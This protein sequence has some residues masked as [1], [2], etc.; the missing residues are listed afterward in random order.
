MTIKKVLM[1]AWIFP[2]LGGSGVQRTLKFSKYLPGLGWKPYI[3][4]SDDPQVFGDGLD[5]SLLTEIPEEAVIWRKPFISPLGF[6]RK[7]QK[8]LRIASKNEF[9]QPRWEENTTSTHSN[10]TNKTEIVKN[11]SQTADPGL[12]QKHFLKRIFAV[13]SIPLAPFEFPPVDAAVYWSLSILPG[14]LKIIRSEKINLIYSTSFPYSDH[15][16]GYLLKRLTGLPWVADFRDPWT[17][18]ASAR[19]QGWRFH[20]DQWVEKKVL[21]SADRILCVTPKYTQGLRRLAPS[22]PP[23]TFLTIENGFDPMDFPAKPAKSQKSSR[24][25]VL[26]HVGYLY[27]GTAIS[28]LNALHLLGESAREL[29]V[30]FIGGLASRE[31]TWLESHSVSAPI[32]ILP[33]QTHR[34]A[35]HAMQQADLLL[36]FIGAGPDWIGNYPGKIFEYMASG[37]PILLIGPQGDSARLLERSGTGKWLPAENSA[38][39]ASFLKLMILNPEETLNS[40][41]HPMLDVVAEYTRQNLTKRLA[42]L[43]GE[44]V[45][46][47][48]R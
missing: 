19:N 38:S 30:R 5:A 35:I 6:R 16:A 2:P 22:R 32:E 4:C 8:T 20:I 7:V 43:F 23:Q 15:L 45:E 11:G 33:R 42:D 26:A 29:A 24:P 12:P 27:D 46:N 41:F 14:C 47:S 13:I 1:I 18:N 9:L 25:L 48:S 3:V 28:F 39:I 37:T 21:L 10:M 36:L 17:E 31:K 44:L 40:F 34:E